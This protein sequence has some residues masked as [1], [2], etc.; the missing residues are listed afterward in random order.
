MLCPTYFHHSLCFHAMHVR[1]TWLQIILDC[2]PVCTF[3]QV[4]D[5]LMVSLA[6]HFRCLVIHN[7]TNVPEKSNLIP[8]RLSGI[9]CKIGVNF[10]PIPC[11]CWT[12]LSKTA[13]NKVLETRKPG[14]SCCRQM[15]SFKRLL[16]NLAIR[17]TGHYNVAI[18]MRKL[19]A[20]LGKSIQKIKYSKIKLANGHILKIAIRKRPFKCLVPS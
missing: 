14:G 5:R 15:K 12:L 10:H 9:W 18:P 3:L 13:A 4:R 11:Q 20:E 7:G 16:L 6:W 17:K 1:E 2:T 19:Q 8:M